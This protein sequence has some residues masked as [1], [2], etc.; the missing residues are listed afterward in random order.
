[1][2]FEFIYNAFVQTVSAIAAVV[3]AV[4]AIRCY[5]ENHSNK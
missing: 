3:S 1:M 4:Y 2:N 5:G